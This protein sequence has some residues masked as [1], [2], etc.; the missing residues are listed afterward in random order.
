MNE[1]NF[2]EGYKVLTGKVDNYPANNK[3]GQVHTGDAWLCAMDRYCQNKTDMPVGLIVFGDKSH[4]DLHGALS[5]TPILFT[6]TLFDCAARNDSKIWKPIGYIP[7]LGYGRGTS[8]KT[9]TRDKIQD[10]HS[11]ISL[12][13]QSL[14]NIIK[15]KG[16]QCVVLG[17]T[18]CVKV[19][20]HFFIGDTKGNNK[21]FGQYPGNREGVRHPYPDCKCQF[22]VLSN[23]NPNCTYLT[24]KDIKFS[25]KG[26]LEDEDAGI[27]Y[28]QS[29]SMHD[30]RNVLTEKSLLLSDNIHGPYKMMPPEL[31][32]TSGT[33]L[34]MYMFESLRDQMAGRKVKN[35]IDKQHIQR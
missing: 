7:N 9:L 29:I 35:L 34:I 24:M 11:C 13:F 22:H 21:W 27:E 17:H 32:H 14:N 31:L 2:A 3:Y 16:F 33:E 25:K 6:L 19:W 20:I 4:T 30:I 1:K 28:Y 18:V 5:L 15:E 23:P 26:K 12:A 10:E 8:N